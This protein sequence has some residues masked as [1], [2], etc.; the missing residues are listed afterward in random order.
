MILDALGDPTRRRII[1][2]LSAGPAS[3]TALAQPLKITLTAVTQHLRVLEEAQ[4]VAT[5][6]VG[7]VRTCRLE[8]AG[9]ET[10]ANWTQ[11]R[12]SIWEHRLDRM[13]EMFKEQP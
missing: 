5:E 8:P 6:K 12:R 10:L 4:L 13:V 11:E 2:R 3:V 1:N 9:F 7:R